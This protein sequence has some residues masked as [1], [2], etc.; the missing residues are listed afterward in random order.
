MFAVAWN[1][2]GFQR[3]DGA[4]PNQA[5]PRMGH[6]KKEQNSDVTR[7]CRIHEGNELPLSRC[8]QAGSRQAPLH[9]E[10]GLKL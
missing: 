8:C 2:G 4:M 6:V 9:D 5:L 1:R 10:G 3:D 7:Y